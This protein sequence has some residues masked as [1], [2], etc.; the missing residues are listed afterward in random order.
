MVNDSQISMNFDILIT[1]SFVFFRLA[2]CRLTTQCCESL[3]SALESSNSPLKELDLSNNY[4]QDSGVNLLSNG[5]KS[6]NCQLNI[7]R[8]DFHMFTI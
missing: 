3:S 1:E 7:L 2:G 6:S 8:C 4:L 5:L